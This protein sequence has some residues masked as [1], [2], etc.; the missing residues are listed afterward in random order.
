MREILSVAGKER[1]QIVQSTT[2]PLP[3]ARRRLASGQT[4]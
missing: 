1:L 4:A 2:S 3:A